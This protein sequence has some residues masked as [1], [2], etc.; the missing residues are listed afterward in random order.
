MDLARI[1][2]AAKRLYEPPPIVTTLVPTSETDAQNWHYT[3][4]EPEPGWTDAAFDDSSWSHGRGGFGT[5]GTP[6][7]VVGTTWDTPSIWLRRTF[8]LDDIPQQGQIALRIHHD[9]DAEVYLNGERI[10]KR[11]GYVSAYTFVPLD[12]DAVGRLKAGRNTLAVH[13]RQA[14]GGQFIDVGIALVTERKP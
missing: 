3:T 8:M 14:R 10:A 11:E 7:A 5:A 1:A 4:A 2:A 12:Q 6:G 13:C 9:E